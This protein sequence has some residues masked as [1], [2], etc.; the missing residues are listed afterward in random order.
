MIFLFL[1]LLKGTADVTDNLKNIILS[2]LSVH[3]T[4]SYLCHGAR[5]NTANEMIKGLSIN[6]IDWSQYEMHIGYKNL[7]ASINV[8][9]FQIV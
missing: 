9:I 2:P 4:L 6:T 5:E 3:V 7:L 1:F 8:I